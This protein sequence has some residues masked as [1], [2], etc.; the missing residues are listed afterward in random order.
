M[1]VRRY[2]CMYVCMQVQEGGRCIGGQLKSLSRLFWLGWGPLKPWTH[3]AS[4][5]ATL[6]FRN[7]PPPRPR[8]MLHVCTYLCHLCMCEI[9]CVYTCV[10][11]HIQMCVCVRVYNYM[12][13]YAHCIYDI[14]MCACLFV[15]TCILFTIKCDAFVQKERERER[16]RERQ[17]ECAVGFDLATG[18][19]CWAL[20]VK[21]RAPH[22]GPEAFGH[23]H[24]SPCPLGWGR[25][26]DGET[27]VEV[28]VHRPSSENFIS[29][30]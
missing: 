7:N 23:R 4:K 11:I 21:I 29:E 30:P 10:Y 9:M 25:I 26:G 24:V 27:K 28:C 17:L 12:C 1:Y 15:W 18:L 8:I 13:T 5:C 20:I 3:H 14:C 22:V 6:L 2:V 19:G 16:E